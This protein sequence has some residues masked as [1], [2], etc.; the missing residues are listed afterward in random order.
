MISIPSILFAPSKDTLR[1]ELDEMKAELAALSA[2]L[3]P[4][5]MEEIEN[6]SFAAT[7]WKSKRRL[8]IQHSGIFTTLF[9]EH[10]FVGMERD[11][12]S[13]LGQRTKVLLIETKSYTYV[14][15]T[16]KGKT[17]VSID[18]QPFCQIVGNECFN[19]HNKKVAAWNNHSKIAHSELKI[20]NR[21]VAAYNSPSKVDK[22]IPRVFSW[23]EDGLEDYEKAILMVFTLRFIFEANI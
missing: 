7:N 8:N 10:V 17:F 11:Y 20:N 2:S 9:H 5:N 13:L 21:V 18:H 4:L 6:F 22:A 15:R 3:I 19:V 14:Y 12:F 1:H 23:I 16:S